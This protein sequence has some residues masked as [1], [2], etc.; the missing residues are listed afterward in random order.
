MLDQQNKLST[1]KYL[2]EAQSSYSHNENI[3]AKCDCM[4]TN[5]TKFNYISLFTTVILT[6]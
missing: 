1:E 3:K 5:S 6:E 4:A 2:I